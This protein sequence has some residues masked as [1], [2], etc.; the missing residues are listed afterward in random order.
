ME[1]NE[2]QTFNNALVAM[3]FLVKGERD[4]AE[5]I[6]DFYEIG[7]LTNC[8]WS[9]DVCSSDLHGDAVRLRKVIS[10]R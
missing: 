4:R 5:R 8:D 6:L 1:N 10:K 2:A 7:K 3:A 9:S